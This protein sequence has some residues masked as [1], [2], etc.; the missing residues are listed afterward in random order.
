MILAFALHKN[1]ILGSNETKSLAKR[2][3]EQNL[4]APGQQEV[5]SNIVLL[6]RLTDPQRDVLRLVWRGYD[7]KEIG[8]QLGVSHYA[9][10]RRIERAVQILGARHRREAARLLAEH[11][12]VTCERIACEP[13]HLPKPPEFAIVERPDKATDGSFPWPFATSGRPDGLGVR[14]RL[15]WA[16]LGI[17]VIV[18][19]AWGVFLSGVGA[20]DALGR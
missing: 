2:G 6:E 7:S 17:P 15:F 18:M 16:L 9:I 20:L 5:R 12:G 14:E 19:L 13:L 8:R 10:N 1:A 4:K 11:D 3:G